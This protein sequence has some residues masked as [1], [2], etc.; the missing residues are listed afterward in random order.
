MKKGCIGA[1]DLII[2][3][4]C[5]GNTKKE[6]RTK[7]ELYEEAGVKEYWVVYPAEQ[8]IAVF[9]LNEKGKYDGAKI[10]AGNDR[11]KLLR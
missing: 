7:F 10:Y 1:P 4:L 8:N 11:T 9:I 2:E 5:A 6:V 3:I